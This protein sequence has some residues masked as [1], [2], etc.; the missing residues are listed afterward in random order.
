MWVRAGM[1]PCLRSAS[2]EEVLDHPCRPSDIFAPF[3]THWDGLLLILE[4]AIPECQPTF[5]GPAFFQGFVTWDSF[6]HITSQS[7]AVILL[8]ALLPALRILNSTMS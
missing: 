8:S 6:R 7:K 3:P 1:R 4:G 5:F 2:C